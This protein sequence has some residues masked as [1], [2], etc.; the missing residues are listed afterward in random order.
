MMRKRAQARAHLVDGG[1]D[2]LSAIWWQFEIRSVKAAVKNL[3]GTHQV[4]RLAGSG[5]EA[6]RFFLLGLF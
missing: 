5:V 4:L 3:E 2:P 1:F 6:L